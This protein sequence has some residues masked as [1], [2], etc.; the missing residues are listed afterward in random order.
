M[1]TTYK[2]PMVLLIALAETDL[3]ATSVAAEALEP[4]EFGMEDNFAL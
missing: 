3:I 2:S 1:K 4:G